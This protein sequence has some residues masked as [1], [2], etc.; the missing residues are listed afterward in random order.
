MDER[1]EKKIVELTKRG[2]K[3][4]GE[5]KIHIQEYVDH[6]FGGAIPGDC[7][8]SYL[9]IRK[10]MHRAREEMYKYAFEQQNSSSV[11][12]SVSSL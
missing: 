6:D 2:V 10:V 5:M 9:D 11:S 7:L 4:V 1:V 12:I 8:P 3:N